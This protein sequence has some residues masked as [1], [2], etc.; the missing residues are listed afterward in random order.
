MNFQLYIKARDS[1]PEA[2]N[3]DDDLDDIII[4]RALEVNTGYTAVQWYTG[5]KT[6]VSFQA[7]FRVTCEQDYYGADCSTH[8]VAK[9]DDVDGHYTCN[10]QNGS[11]QCLE[12]FENPSNNCMDSKLILQTV[13]IE[14]YLDSTLPHNIMPVS[15]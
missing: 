6:A 4:N 13:T 14:L 9:D 7:H 10:W 5:I 15:L 12:G 8:C 11:I 1:D 3:E 2:F